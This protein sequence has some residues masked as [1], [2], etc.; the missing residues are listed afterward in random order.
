M[1]GDAQSILDAAV[2][3]AGALSTRGDPGT[4]SGE[5]ACA[6]AVCKILANAGVPIKPTLSTTELQGEMVNA[7]FSEV[8]PSTPG[9]VIVSPTSGGRHGHTGV[10]G[11]DGKIYSNSSKEGMWEQNYTLDKWNQSFGDLGVHAYLPPGSAAATTHPSISGENVDYS[12]Y[13]QKKKK[14]EE[15]P[16]PELPEPPQF[17]PA[18][19]PE[20]PRFEPLEPVERTIPQR[21]QRPQHE[22]AAR[23]PAQE[24]DMM[25]VNQWLDEVDHL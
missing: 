24:D 2:A 13:A 22:F 17:K 14:R 11:Y 19:L 3:G 1:P 23:H 20:P 9:A 8:D 15:P 25:E 6:D 5:L 4:Q 18:E 7:G 16:T 12:D 10:V 21:V